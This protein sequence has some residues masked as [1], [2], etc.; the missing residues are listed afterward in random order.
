MAGGIGGT[1]PLWN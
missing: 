1:V